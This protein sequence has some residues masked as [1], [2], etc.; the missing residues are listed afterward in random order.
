MPKIDIILPPGYL[1]EYK[2]KFSAIKKPW[3]INVNII[4]NKN[5]TF[6]FY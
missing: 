2:S 1:E 6:M 4:K 3:W 5:N